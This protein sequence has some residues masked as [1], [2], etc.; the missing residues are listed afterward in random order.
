MKMML[1][2]LSVLLMAVMMASCMTAV[3][4]ADGET[5]E[6]PSGKFYKYGVYEPEETELYDSGRVKVLCNRV[7]LTTGATAEIV[8][9]S[10]NYTQAKIGETVYLPVVDEEAKTSTFVLPV[11]INAPTSFKATTV[12]MGGSPKEIDYTVTVK[13]DENNLKPAQMTYQDGFYTTAAST[14]I[15]S[16]GYKT[17]KKT[18]EITQVGILYP[19]KNY[20]LPV[21]VQVEGGKVVD[22][23]YPVDITGVTVNTSSDFNYL[24]WGMDGHQVSDDSYEYLKDGSYTTY[25]LD[26]IPARNDKGMAEQIIAKN[27]ITGVDTVSKATITSRAIIDSVDQS[28]IKAANGQKDDPAPEK[29]QEDTTEDIIPEDGYYTAK[30]ECI[31]A[32]LSADHDIL[33]EVKDGKITAKL[34][35]IE[36]RESSYPHIFAGTEKEALEAGESAW[37][38]PED[39]DYGNRSS[40]GVIYPG[41][42]YKDVPIKSLDKNLHFMMFASS[43]DTWYNRMIKIDAST[44]KELSESEVAVQNAQ[45]EY[46][47]ADVAA[48][49]AEQAVEKAIDK[50][51]ATVESIKKA[52]DA[53]AAATKE[54]QKK[55]E[56]LNDAKDVVAEEKEEAVKAAEAA[57]KD[58]EDAKDAADAEVIKAKKAAEDAAQMQA[59]AEAAQ[60]KAE[61]DKTASDTAKAK[62]EADAKAAK[63]ASDKAAADLKAAQ[64]AQAK[65]E[66]DLKKANEDLTQAKA[67]LE[68][69]TAAAADTSKLDE[70]TV[71][72]QQ[73][74]KV[75]AKKGKKKATVSWKSLGKGYKYQVYVSTKAEK[76]FKK[77]ATASKAKT[78]V[79]K[80]KSKKTYYI[81]V[82]GFK[83]V[84]GKNVYTAFSDIAKVKV[85]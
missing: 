9:T 48:K 11:N 39:Y 75:K 41:S 59:D 44:L 4:F 76:G 69:A 45:A 28:L 7:H 61:A 34:M 18:G 8:F 33:L 73:V 67:D 20:D 56:A 29:P 1:R 27:G 12:A 3:A 79:K 71:K 52:N 65:A 62:A 5:T 24:V 82:R 83:T 22:V 42:L 77:K 54:A 37:L 25:H 63:E 40:K 85:K 55:L 2:K 72:A 15:K 19:N 70:L 23:F 60:K 84:N 51:G 10:K 26:P 74:K 35:Y 16:Y 43:S 78:V 66:A 21:T 49:I 50:D 53:Y 58:A 57:Q 46:L 64:D 6:E 80:L 32:D 30:G 17:D 14:N 47:I 36:Q 31:G 68:K 38:K 13:L 81:K